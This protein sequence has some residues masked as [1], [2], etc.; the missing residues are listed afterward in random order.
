MN[1]FSIIKLI[2]LEK[3]PKNLWRKCCLT[4]REKAYF[5]AEKMLNR[6]TSVVRLVRDM[7]L[8]QKILKK[9]TKPEELT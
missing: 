4:R 7:R 9:L 6:E 2:L 8:I 3:F 5:A 1:I